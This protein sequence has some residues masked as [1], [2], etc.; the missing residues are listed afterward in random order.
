VRLVTKGPTWIRVGPNFQSPRMFLTR[1]ASQLMRGGKT[2]PRGPVPE[3]II[4]DPVGSRI[5]TET[6]SKCEGMIQ[7]KGS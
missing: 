1:R 7:T 2:N 4:D 5:A 3:Q 6:H